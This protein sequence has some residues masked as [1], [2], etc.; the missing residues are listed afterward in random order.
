[1]Y[2]RT[3]R[4][5]LA[6]ERVLDLVAVWQHIELE[7]IAAGKKN[8]HSHLDVEEFRFMY[9]VSACTEPSDEMT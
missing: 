4:S 2:V 6:E 7:A 8:P 1:M 5:L 9:K 3:A